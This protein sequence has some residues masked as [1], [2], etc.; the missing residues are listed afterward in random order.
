M[1][2]PGLLERADTT[3]ALLL[4]PRVGGGGGPARGRDGCNRPYAFEN[5]GEKNTNG[6]IMILTGEH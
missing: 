6:G 1:A 2:Q 4:E 5:E 3:V